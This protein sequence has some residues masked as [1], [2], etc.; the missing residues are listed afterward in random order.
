MS[1]QPVGYTPEVKEAIKKAHDRIASLRGER[2]TFRGQCKSLEAQLKEANDRIQI[3][4]L[5]LGEAVKDMP[6]ESD[7]YCV[8]LDCKYSDILINDEDK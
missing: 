1:F 6:Y 5:A 4:N 7:T 2:N 8:S 3:L